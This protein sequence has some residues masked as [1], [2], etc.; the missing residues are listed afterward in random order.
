MNN[1]LFVHVHTLPTG[2][3]IIH[4]HPFFPASDSSENSVPHSH[5]KNEFLI[6]GFLN[7]TLY[8]VMFIVVISA[9]FGF[10]RVKKSLFYNS[11]VLNNKICDYF[12]RPP[13]ISFLYVYKTGD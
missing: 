5:N 2:E 13:P 3:I 6:Y 4:A 1:S 11:I 10:I 8:L 9:I 7:N 12:N